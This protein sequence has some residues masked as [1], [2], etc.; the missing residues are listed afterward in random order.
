[1]RPFR[2]TQ[3]RRR[4]GLMSFLVIIFPSVLRRAV[5]WCCVGSIGRLSRCRSL[6]QHTLHCGE[7]ALVL[8]S[9]L[10]DPFAALSWRQ[11]L[12]SSAQLSGWPCVSV[13]PCGGPL[14]LPRLVLLM[15]LWRGSSGGCPVHGSATVLAGFPLGC[16][17]GW[18]SS[19]C[20][21][22]LRVGRSGH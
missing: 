8:F 3:G 7:F 11:C 14:L 1:M 18:L 12:L 13:L 20:V 16:L 10:V 22:R 4:R 5:F 21:A 15:V 19:V 2:S 17:I 9:A 6:C